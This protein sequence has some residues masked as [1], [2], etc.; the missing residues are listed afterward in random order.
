MRRNFT[1]LVLLLSATSL[2]ATGHGGNDPTKPD[3]K[4]KGKGKV[5]EVA[6]APAP[7]A[8]VGPTPPPFQSKDDICYTCFFTK[9]EHL[10]ADL[11]P[12]ILGHVKSDPLV[13]GDEMLI[14]DRVRGFKSDC[15]AVAAHYS[16][17][18]GD[19]DPSRRLTADLGLAM[20]PKGCAIDWASMTRAAADA[21]AALRH[22]EAKLLLEI[23]TQQFNFKP[24][25][26][27]QVIETDLTPIL[28]ATTMILGESE[29]PLPSGTRVGTQV[30]RVVRDWDSHQLNWDYR[31]AVINSDNILSYHE[32]ALVKKMLSI[33]PYLMITPLS[34]TIVARDPKT[35]LWFAPDEKGVFRF[36]VLDD[37]LQYPTTH[38]MGDVA[39]ITDT[40]G[41]SAIVSQAVELNSQLVVACGDSIGKVQ[42]AFYLAQKGINVAMP[43][44]RFNYMLVGYKGTG[45]II[46]GAPVHMVDGVP[47]YGHQPVRF[48]MK[49]VIVVEDTDVD[50][51]IQY[52]DA[53]AK[54]FHRLASIVPISPVYVKVTGTDQLDRIFSIA[55]DNAT[56]AI[57]VRVTTWDEDQ[58]LRKWLNEDSKR[59]AILFHSGLYKYAQGL[60]ADFPTQVTF[61]DLRPRFE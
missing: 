31:P 12:S 19:I 22:S 15:S 54:Y 34:G 37:K 43:A 16:R 23:S 52:Y 45:T 35:N 11:L 8:M 10:P 38:S 14:A 40:H 17:A 29:I 32:G 47:V 58:S 5:I 51:P 57:A 28:G 24:E 50:Y 6:A 59:R 13:N 2:F 25:F 41:V 3:P 60:F 36:N 18:T 39:W 49:D 42:A 20:P 61:G 27:T 26:G 46:G 4:K 30:E 44:D 48:A 53:P 7:V 1:L 55:R 56:T 33:S 9:D 21:T